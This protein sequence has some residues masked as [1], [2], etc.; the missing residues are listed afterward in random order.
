M[1]SWRPL[2]RNKEL[3][4]AKPAN[5]H[6]ITFSIG[7][8]KWKIKSQSLEDTSRVHEHLSLHIPFGAFKPSYTFIL[9]GHQRRLSHRNVQS[10]LN[11]KS[12]TDLRTNTQISASTANNKLNVFKAKKWNWNSETYYVICKFF[13]GDD[14]ESSFPK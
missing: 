10:Q 7:I 4:W 13:Y 3:P 11:F 6:S 2:V 5:T 12:T 9:G 8:L 1:R 14:Y